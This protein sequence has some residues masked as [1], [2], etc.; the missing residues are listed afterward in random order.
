MVVI[1]FFTKQI[2]YELRDI[3]HFEQCMPCDKYSINVA[4]LL[5]P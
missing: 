4:I 1:R 3:E 2:L 5:L